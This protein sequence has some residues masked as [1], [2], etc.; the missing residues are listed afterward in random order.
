M[1]R[2]QIIALTPPGL[3]DSSIAIAA[4]RAGS[5][6]VLDLEYTTDLKIARDCLNK[7]A[8]FTRNE[9]GIS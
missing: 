8:R 7:L 6:G 4:C 5:L 3:P 2:F 1:K 9:F